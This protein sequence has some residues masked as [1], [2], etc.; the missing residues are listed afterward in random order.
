MAS[1][2]LN[3]K[4]RE[5]LKKNELIFNTW[6]KFYNR[7]LE[8]IEKKKFD[9]EYKFINRSNNSENLCIVLAGYKELIWDDVFTRLEKYAPKDLDICIMSSGKYSDKL[10]EMCEKNNWS[11][12]SLKENSVTLIQNIAIN[13]YPNA[14]YIYKMDEDIFLTKGFFEN[15]KETFLRV[16]KET[17]FKISFVAPLIPINGYTYIKILE[18][19]NLIEDFDSKFGKAMYDATPGE[20]IIENPEIAQYL[21]RNTQDKLKDIDKLSEEFSK[22]EFEYSICPIRYS[23]GAIMFPRETW[24]RMGKFQVLKGTNLGADEVQLCSYGSSESRI[25]VVSHNNVVGHFGYGP[26]SKAMNEYY[27]KNREQFKLKI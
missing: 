18:K 11:Y 12:L 10:N 3:R 20:K 16:E 22:N 23:I 5:K 2:T 13:L 14:K 15:L 26:Q 17:R 27:N 9:G 1:M 25:I 4:I 7:K 8:K 6:K 24:E 21:W 19:T